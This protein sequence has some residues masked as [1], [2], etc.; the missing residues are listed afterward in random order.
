MLSLAVKVGFGSCFY[1]LMFDRYRLVEVGSSGF[2]DL[3][4]GPD[5]MN[6]SWM[7]SRVCSLDRSSPENE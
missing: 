5:W 4:D 3:C 2:L 6:G 7:R 1:H